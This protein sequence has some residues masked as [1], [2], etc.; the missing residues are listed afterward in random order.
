MLLFALVGLAGCG[1]VGGFL[2]STGVF[3][4]CGPLPT[5]PD[6]CGGGWV[7]TLFGSDGEGR[8]LRDV[9]DEECREL[10][11]PYTGDH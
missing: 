6:Q 10:D 9:T 4:N 1:A 7:K 8:A 11:G 3:I 2:T 5:S